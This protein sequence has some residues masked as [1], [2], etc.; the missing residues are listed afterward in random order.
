MQA[1]SGDGGLLKYLAGHTTAWWATLKIIS[2]LGPFIMSNLDAAD[3]IASVLTT[4]WV[5]L[6]GFRLCKLD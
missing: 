1:R 4:I 2:V 6:L 5:V 3:I